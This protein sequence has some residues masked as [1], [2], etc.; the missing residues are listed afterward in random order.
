MNNNLSAME[1]YMNRVFKIV[2]LAC[3]LSALAAGLTYSTIRLLG[4]YNNVS[5]T[6]LAIFD[7]SCLIYFFIGLYFVSHCE[8]KNGLIKPG[9]L[10]HG[11]I[12]LIFVEIIQWNFITYLMPSRDFWAYSAYFVMLVVFFLDSKFVLIVGGEIYVSLV[13]SWFIKGGA[14]LPLRDHNYVPNIIQRAVF[15]LL[16][17]ICLWAITYIV[18]K[19]LVSELEKISDYDPLTSLR[20]R[21]SLSR[22]YDETLEHMAKN[23]SKYSFIMC[24][25]D[26]FKYVN[27]TYG[28][29]LGDEVLRWVAHTILS[30]MGGDNFCFRYGGEEMLLLVRGDCDQAYE[31]SERIRKR[32]E[33]GVVPYSDKVIKITLTLGVSEINPGLSMDDNIKKADVNLYY[34]KTHGKNQSVK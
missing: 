2:I 17:L 16:V 14:L 5:L 27:D 24:D 22:S 13:V 4:Y 31:V 34:G 26:D 1:L 33:D 11:K 21:R 12:F 10:K 25:L 32:I 15:L 19:A 7:L 23:N 30:Q 6:G 20:N 9:I 18:E 3:P 29:D 28:H 8:D